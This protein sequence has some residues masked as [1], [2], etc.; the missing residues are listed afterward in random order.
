MAEIDVPEASTGRARFL[1]ALWPFFWPYRWGLLAALLAIITASVTVLALGQGLRIVVDEG[2]A[3]G[4]AETLHRGIL[5]LVGAALLLAVASYSRSMLVNSIGDA[6]ASALRQGLMRHW[7]SL[8]VA[9]FE[10]QRSGDLLSRL[11]AD[12]TLLQVVL[13]GAFPVAV[14]NMLTA[15]GGLMLMAVASGR[16]TLVVLGCLPIVLLPPVVFLRRVRAASKIAQDIAAAA[17][18]TAQQ[19]LQEIRTVQSLVAEKSVLQG[20]ISHEAVALKIA[21]RRNR[22]RALLSASVIALVF[23]SL[24]VVLWYG[25][26]AVLAGQ[27]TPGALTAFLFY[28]LVAAGAMGSLSEIGGDLQKA[29]GAAERILA[30]LEVSSALTL[31]PPTGT[32]NGTGTVVFAGVSFAYPLAPS[33]AVYRDFNLSLASGEMVA[34]VGSSGSGKTTLFQLLLRFYDPQAGVVRVDGVDIRRIPLADLRRAVAW[35]GQEPILFDGTVRDN[36]LLGIE[37]SIDE[38]KV[39]AALTQ[40]SAEAFVAALPEGLQTVVGERGLRLSVGQRQRL[41]LARALLRRPSILLLD[42]YTA[43]LDALTEATILKALEP[44]R[45]KTTILLSAHRLATAKAADRIVLLE[46]GTLL[47]TGTHAELVEKE[48]LY[49]S[50]V[51][52]QGV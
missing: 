19:A 22:T 46:A 25:G 12:T 30:M 47:A 29:G 15:M 39:Q 51:R 33:V 20:L 26:I 23:L 42:E 9:F 11:S 36:L 49:A 41:T 28:A 40:A 17:T 8:D 35:V 34:L 48:P 2:L 52:V 1:R 43:S 16:L 24:G 50:M 14:R 32:L 6:V 37:D 18:S 45:G 13:T 27:L 10:R 5:V 31:L 3:A 38:E 44:L 7:L 4:N 21:R